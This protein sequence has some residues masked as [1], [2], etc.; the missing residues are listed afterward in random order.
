MNFVH[1]PV[2]LKLENALFRKLGLF[3]FAGEGEV[4]MPWDFP[5]MMK[6]KVQTGF[7]PSPHLKT[8]AD[9]VSETSRYLVF[10]VPNNGQSPKTQ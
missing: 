5:L 4:T 8:E 10:I 3:L 9:P 7:R 1:R 2:L 6:L